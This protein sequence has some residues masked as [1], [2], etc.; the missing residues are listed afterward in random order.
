MSKDIIRQMT[1]EECREW[2]LFE[3]LAS[4]EHERWAGWQAYLH[5]K[6]IKNDDGSLTIPAGYVFHLERLIKTSYENLTEKEKESDRKE[7]KK[8]W[9]FIKNGV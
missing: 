7:V 4:I 8:Y 1:D 6:C 2:G 5:S 9:S 3:K